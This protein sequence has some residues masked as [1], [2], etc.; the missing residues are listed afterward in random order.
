[1]M[2]DHQPPVRSNKRATP[3]RCTSPLLPQDDSEEHQN[4]PQ[5]DQLLNNIKAVETYVRSDDQEDIPTDNHPS[6][7]TR[8]SEEHLMLSDFKTNN[9]G[10]TEDT[11]EEHAIISDVSSA[12]HSKA[13]SSYPLDGFRS[14]D[15]SQTVKQSVQHQR[16]EGEKAFLCSECGKH[17]NHESHIVMYKKIC[18]AYPCSECGK[19]FNH[20]SHLVQHHKIHT[21]EKPYSCSEC[22][23]CFNHKS[24]LAIHERTHTGEKPYSCSECGKRFSETSGLRR[25]KRIHTGEKPYTC[26]ECSYNIGSDYTVVKQTSSEHGQA[27]VSEG[28]GGILSP[29][30]RPTPPIPIH[31]KV[32][33]EKIL[34]LTNKI[35]ELLT[36]ELLNNI[37]AEDTYVRSDEQIIEDIPP[38]NHPEGRSITGVHDAK[39]AKREGLPRDQWTDVIVLFPASGLQQVYFYL[40]DEKAADYKNIKG[41]I[42]ARLRVNVLVRAQR[43]YQ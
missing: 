41:E 39:L 14:F 5:Y 31:E 3:V 30:S 11:R 43:V 9:S 36:G 21:G 17:F 8:S 22:G 20:K 4:V 15:S 6:D 12:F 32:N 13:L 37:K 7:C 27:P 10:V 35:I 19:S 38:D 28:R 24:R 23:K 18:K 40:P 1:M 29:I 16:T 42:L 25:H 26:L 2:E 34:E 33:I